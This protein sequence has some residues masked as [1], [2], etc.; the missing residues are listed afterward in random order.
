MCMYFQNY[1]IIF[2]IEYP[3]MKIPVK[4]DLA[5]RIIGWIIELSKFQIQYQPRGQL[6]LRPWPI[7]QSRSTLILWMRTPSGSCMLMGL[8][9]VDHAM[10]GSARRT[11]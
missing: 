7:L 1:R 4:S 5:G 2:N 3:I 10:Q 6:N 11:K 8:L 9:I